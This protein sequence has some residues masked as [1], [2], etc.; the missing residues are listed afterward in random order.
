MAT[1]KRVTMVKEAITVGM[2][3]MGAKTENTMA[4]TATTGTMVIMGRKV[5]K[6][7]ATTETGTES[8]ASRRPLR[9]QKRVAGKKAMKDEHEF[10]GR[11]GRGPCGEHNHPHDG[12]LISLFHQCMHRI[13]HADGRHSSQSRL[14]TIL[15]E[16]GE[17]SQKEMQERLRIQ[18][19]SLSELVSKLEAKGLL[20]RERD[21]SDKRKISLRI[22]PDGLEV[23]NQVPQEEERPDPF[24]VLTEAEQKTLQELLIKIMENKAK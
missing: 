16:E 10:K 19:G 12:S 7:T 22:T 17:L 5:E 21:E 9:P 1:G 4:I 2:V 20:T 6:V 13:H 23:V 18:A 11:H 15:A 24:S 3:T 14:L 8:T